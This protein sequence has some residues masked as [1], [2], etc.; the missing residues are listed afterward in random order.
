MK[1]PQN[2]VKFRLDGFP[3]DALDQ[4]RMRHL[5]ITS[6]RTGVPIAKLI[7]EALDQ[8]VE[9]WKAEAELPRKIVKFPAAARYLRSNLLD[10]QIRR[11]FLSTV[12]W[13][14]ERTA[15]SRNR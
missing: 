1:T 9:A 6:D 13:I 7:R 4:T 11:E 5:R 10:R 8:T 15:P 2:V 14:H 12:E 3:L